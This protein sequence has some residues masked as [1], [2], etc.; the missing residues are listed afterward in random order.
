[1]KYPIQHQAAVSARKIARLRRRRRPTYSEDARR[2]PIRGALL[3]GIVGVLLLLT[4]AVSLASTPAR[5][6][7]QSA[8]TVVSVAAT[9]QRRIDQEVDQI[10]AHNVDSRRLNATSVLLAPGVVVTVPGPVAAGTRLSL[11]NSDGDT[12]MTTMAASQACDRGYLC[13][14]I[15]S[16]KRGERLALWRCGDVELSQMYWG[17]RGQYTWQDNASSIFDNQTGSPISYF[18]DYDSNGRPYALGAARPG[19]YWADL[20]YKST[21]G[22]AWNDRIDKVHVC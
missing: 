2:R 8:G 19:T 21:N 11:P 9:D 5:T 13:L 3:G 15:D 4:P 6:P 1:M 14:W 7:A 17:S 16:H 22:H 20:A 10:L 12:Q 18:Y